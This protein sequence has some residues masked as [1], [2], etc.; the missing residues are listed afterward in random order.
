MLTTTGR[1]IRGRASPEHAPGFRARLRKIVSADHDRVEA[2][3]ERL[4]LTRSDDLVDFLLAHGFALGTVR[5]ALG[6]KSEPWPVRIDHMLALIATDLAAIGRVPPASFATEPPALHPLGP[7]YVVAGS[8][9]GAA[10]LSDRLGRAHDPRVRQ[11]AR[12]LSWRLPRG[13]WRGVCES[14]DA[15]GDPAEAR[16]II[17]GARWAFGVFERAALEIREGVHV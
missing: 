16:A 17:E 12:Y 11:A 14:L 5:P 7:I 10:I 15:I 9:L 2:A 1:G 13:A 3:F 8:R 6:P 4:D